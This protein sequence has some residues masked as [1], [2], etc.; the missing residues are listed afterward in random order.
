LQL[1]RHEKKFSGHKTN[2]V[3]LD[4]AGQA[5]DNGKLPKPSNFT[6]RIQ[7]PFLNLE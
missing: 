4:R 5:A 3:A 2:I 6:R 7:L 1:S